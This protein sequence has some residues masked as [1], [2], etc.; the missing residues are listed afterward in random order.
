MEN[1]DEFEF[2]PP[3]GKEVYNVLFDGICLSFTLPSGEN[4]SMRGEIRF[5]TL[6]VIGDDD[7]PEHT[8]GIFFGNYE[9]DDFYYP[10]AV[11]FEDT[12]GVICEQP[13]RIPECCVVTDVCASYLTLEDPAGSYICCIREPS[14]PWDPLRAVAVGRISHLLFRY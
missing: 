12:T 6:T 2:D 10:V 14:L 13:Q 3:H 9:V 11:H 7:V 1:N 5:H 8:S 4:V